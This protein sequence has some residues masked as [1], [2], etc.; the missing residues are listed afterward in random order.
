MQATENT[1]ALITKLKSSSHLDTLIVT[2]IQKMSNIKQE[3]AGINVND[4]EEINRKR[5]VFIIDEAHRST[6]GDML[7]TIKDTFPKAIFFGF[8]GTPIQDENQKKGNTTSTV[9]GNELHRYSIADGIRDKN[10]LG[11]DP[12]KVLTYKDKDLRTAVALE[13]AKADTI[14]E[15]E[16]MLKQ[17]IADGSA[18]KKLAE[19]VEAQGGDAEVV[20]HPEQ[21]PKANYI[22]DIP[23]PEEGY[24]S[25][26]ICDE[27]GICSLLLGGGRETKESTIDLSVGLVL[28]KKVGDYVKKGEALAQI[29]GNNKEKMQAAAKRFLESYRFSS[30]P[31]EKQPFIKAVIG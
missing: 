3:E 15:A 19:F 9:F 27:I 29:H 18:L 20:Y 25:R 4:I 28:Y 14:E 26:I 21:L 13:Q 1:G 6:F 24:V 23:S 7:I 10:I 11:F 31:V 5:L 2:S 16:A 30:E 8:T 17:V 22:E 12:Y